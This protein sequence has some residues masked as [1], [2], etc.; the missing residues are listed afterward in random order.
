MSKTN[1]GKQRCSV[2]SSQT[3]CQSRKTATSFRSHQKQRWQSRL[4]CP[5]GPPLPQPLQH[6]QR[7]QAWLPPC[8][9]AAAAA[10]AWPLQ[11]WPLPPCERSLLQLPRL[12]CLRRR[13]WPGQWRPAGAG[14]PP[15]AP[16]P[17]PRPGRTL[18]RRELAHWRMALPCPWLSPS[19]SSCRR[20]CRWTFGGPEPPAR[21]NRRNKNQV[22]GTLVLGTP[23]R[24]QCT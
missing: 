2:L 17:Q 14:F 12:R 15:R 3:A 22:Q 10:A 24:L 4:R 7:P 11:R 13:P 21:C 6:A 20:R 23:R 9:C 5:P 18:F 19:S 1:A 16:R 8:P